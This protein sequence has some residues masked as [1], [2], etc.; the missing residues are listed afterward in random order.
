ML[1][2]E[3]RVKE[4]KSCCHYFRGVTI[5]GFCIDDRIILIQLVTTLH[6]SLCDTLYLLSLL[7]SSLAV[8]W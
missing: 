4:G 5:D 7:Q 1:A 3:I 2:L 8:A 6:K